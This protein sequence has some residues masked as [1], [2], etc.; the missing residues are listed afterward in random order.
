MD[1]SDQAHKD[2]TTT[3]SELSGPGGKKKEIRQQALLQ[4]IEN[5]H[6]V[7]LEEIAERFHV[8]TQTARRD[9]ADLEHRGKVRKL[10]GGVSQLTPLDPVTY[11]QRRHDRADEKVRIAE[12]VVALIP[13][14]ATVFLD[15]GTT[16]EAIAN[17]LV[18]RER[19]HLVTY[20]LR[21][22]AIISEK[23]DFTLA[24]PGGFVRP[25]DGGMFQ[26]DTPEFIRRFKFDYAIISVSGIDDDGDLCDDDHTEVAVVSAALGQAAHKLLAVDSSKFGRRA[27]VKLGSVRDV[28]ALVTNETPAPILARILEE[29]NIPVILS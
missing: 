22:A 9:I 18:S 23:T 21:S 6:Y 20:S 15:T 28:S 26:E 16:C 13:D 7:S 12:A 1:Q 10:H 8:T 5:S 29:A 14:G 25:I 2:I 4:W 19:L 3:M 17:A 27:M 24:V 11:R